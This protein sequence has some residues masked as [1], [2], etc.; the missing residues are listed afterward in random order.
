MEDGYI[1]R[2]K[3]LHRLGRWTSYVSNCGDRETEE[4][5]MIA[6]ITALSE[7]EMAAYN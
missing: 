2:R 1:Q 3:A 6:S 4:L 5:A 7:K